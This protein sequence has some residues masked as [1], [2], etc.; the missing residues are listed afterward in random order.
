[1]IILN[2]KTNIYIMN[3]L[4][5]LNWILL[6]LDIPKLAWLYKKNVGFVFFNVGSVFR[7]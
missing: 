4:T 6:L 3:W 1:M 2:M 5:V 7:F